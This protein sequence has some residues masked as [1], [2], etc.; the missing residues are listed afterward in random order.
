MEFE[1]VIDKVLAHEGGYVNDPDDPGGETN[2][3]ISKRAYPNTDIKNLTIEGAKFIYKRDYWVKSKANLLP[4]EL[5]YIHFDTA[6]NMGRARAAKLLQTS[7]KS[8][9]DGIIGPNTLKAVEARGSLR[10][11]AIERF[12]YYNKIIVNNPTSIKYVRGW[13]GRVIDIILTN[14]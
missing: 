5:R 8:T 4:P 13:F 9:P 1:E 12:K 10:N 14:K 2:Y 3:G 11:Y 6:V 7:V